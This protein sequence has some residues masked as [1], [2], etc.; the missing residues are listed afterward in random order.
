MTDDRSSS[1]RGDPL[2]AYLKEISHL[3]PLSREEEKRLATSGGK[4]DLEELVTH[5]L[6]YVVMVANRYKGMGLSLPD[7]INEGNIGLMEAAR[8]FDPKRG[9]K[10]IT[11]AVWWVR[12]SILRAMAEQSGVI[13][14]PVKQAGLISRTTKTIERLTHELKRE[15][16]LDEVAAA[17][18]VK[19]QTLTTILRVYRDYVSLDSP[20]SDEDDTVR[21]V[22][23]LESDPGGSMEA[24][25]VRLCF[26]KDIARLL[27]ELPPR[28]RDVLR[29]RYGFD[30]SPMTLEEI[31]KRMD[32]TRERIRQIEKVA[33]EKLRTRTSL[34]IL[35]DYA[36]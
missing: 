16:N 35:E 1:D 26:H 14:L 18:K 10:F 36:R 20:L 19:R 23:M 31:G 5:N 8:R 3:S 22:D 33:K 4:Q 27:S 25:Y 21:F 34:K 12:Q 29:M 9:V 2:A 32:L 28:E 24:D 7:L 13:R 11:Y 6:K 15:P 17:M 30:D